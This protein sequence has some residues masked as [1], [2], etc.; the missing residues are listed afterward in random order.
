MDD[1]GDV[2]R[3]GVIPAGVAV[4]EALKAARARAAT[5]DVVPLVTAAWNQ[6]EVLRG[7][8]PRLAPWIEVVEAI[9]RRN[10]A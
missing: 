7:R 4:A 10:A 6:A 9:V 8:C 1:V 3:D 2:H 5:R